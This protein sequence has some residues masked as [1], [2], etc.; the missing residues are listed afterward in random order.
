MRAIRLRTEHLRDP[1]GVDFTAPR[2]VW[3][4]EGGKRQTAY[5]ITAADDTGQQLWDSGWVESASMRAQWGGPAVAPGTKAV[6]SV[7]LWDE[8]GTAGDWAQASFETG[9][10]SWRAQWITGSYKV[11]KSRRYPV[12]CFRKAF[13][14]Q[15][16]RKARLYITAC[17]LYEARLNGKRVGGLHSC[18]WDYRL[19]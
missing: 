15:D 1:I 3:N 19:P 10:G 2:L 6:W 5:Q 12:D 13:A 11:R 9:I 17:G 8:T 7:R 14:A 18:P 16:I 4:C